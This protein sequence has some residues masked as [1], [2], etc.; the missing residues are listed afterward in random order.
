MVIDSLIPQLQPNKSEH[1]INYCLQIKYNFIRTTSTCV[2]CKEMLE[3][4]TQ[5]NS[6]IYIDVMCV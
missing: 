1:V 6:K 2:Q 3:S 5:H 4:A